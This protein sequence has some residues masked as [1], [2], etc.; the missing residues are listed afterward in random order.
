LNFK[1]TA[2]YDQSKTNFIY[3]RV[4]VT[5]QRQERSCREPDSREAFSVCVHC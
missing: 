4:T 5:N 3:H 1:L 2:N